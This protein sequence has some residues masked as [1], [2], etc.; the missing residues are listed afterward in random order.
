MQPASAFIPATTEA[1]P[2]SGPLHC[3][4]QSYSGGTQMHC[5]GGV[6]GH[7][8]WCNDLVMFVENG[9]SGGFIRTWT[10]TRRED[11]IFERY[12]LQGE[13]PPEIAR[14]Q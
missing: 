13:V 4:Q 5:E 6:P 8:R 1:S 11:E 2:V 3:S 12:C 14:L 10:G 9:V 7:A